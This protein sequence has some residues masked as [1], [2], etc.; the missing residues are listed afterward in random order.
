M[1]RHPSRSPRPRLTTALMAAALLLAGCASAPPDYVTQTKD[2]W[3]KMNRAIYGFND[4]LDKAVVRPVANT[5]V[6]AMPAPA[7]NRFHDFLNNLYE[8]VTVF[9]DLLQG[10]VKQTLQDTGRFLVNSTAGLFG[11]FDVAKDVGL[12]HHDEDFGETLAHW[13]VPSG[14][15]LVIP[16]LGPSTVRDAGGRIVD[17]YPNPPLNNIPTRYRNGAVVMYG[18]DTRVGL[19][20][21]NA[22]IDSAYD[23]YAFVR[24]AYLQNRRYNIYDGNPPM[25]YP[26]YPDVDEDENAPAA[27]SGTGPAAAASGASPTTT[28]PAAG[29]RAA[30]T[31]AAPG[32][33]TRPAASPPAK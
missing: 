9:N 32:A 29:T 11:F 23:P 33:A 26:D 30:P 13:G 27:A 3:E 5:Y 6:R 25:Q 17:I 22:S 10:K 7:R 28:A 18:L 24:D 4:K 8:P 2:P 21:A 16:I 15:Y 1:S 19:M 31:V 14:P 20:Q 12:S